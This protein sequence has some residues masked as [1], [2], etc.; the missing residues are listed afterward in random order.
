MKLQAIKKRCLATKK[1]IIVNA[2]DGSQWISDG[3]NYY[4]IVGIRLKEG[5][6]QDVFGLKNKQMEHMYIDTEGRRE[7]F[8]EERYNPIGE[9]VDYLRDVWA[10]DQQIHAFATGHGVL[11]IT[12]E[13]TK[14]S[15]FEDLSDLR[16]L[17]DQQRNPLVAV[18]NGIFCDALLS[19]IPAEFAERIRQNMQEIVDKPVFGLEVSDIEEADVK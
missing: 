18:Y 8:F 17:Y 5:W 1:M 16:L 19:P 6:L 9:G 7:E 2:G 13:Q 11:Y 3:L 12:E 10:F 15:M 14:P 4:R